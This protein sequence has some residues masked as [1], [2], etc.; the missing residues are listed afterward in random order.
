MWISAKDQLFNTDHINYIE[1][2]EE[3]LRF[4]SGDFSYYI[5]I[6]FGKSDDCVLDFDSKKDRDKCFLEYTKILLK[7]KKV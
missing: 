3:E 1:R 6:I 5:R 7:T 2:Y 4:A